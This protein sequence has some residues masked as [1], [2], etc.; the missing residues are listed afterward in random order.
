MFKYIYDT[1]DTIYCS[2]LYDSTFY[3]IYGR[4]S[5]FP[6]GLISILITFPTDIYEM[7]GLVQREGAITHQ[8]RY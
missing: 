1:I 8:T 5:S 6:V 7:H 2:L 3:N 4:R